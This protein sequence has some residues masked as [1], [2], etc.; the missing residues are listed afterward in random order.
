MSIQMRTLSR[1]SARVIS[2]MAKNQHNGAERVTSTTRRRLFFFIFACRTSVVG[3]YDGSARHP[4]KK[5]LHPPCFVSL[6]TKCDLE[7]AVQ[8]SSA[9]TSLNEHTIQGKASS[10]IRCSYRTLGRIHGNPN[11]ES[12]S[13]YNL[14]RRIATPSISQRTI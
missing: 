7:R 3:S 11:I 13:K 5:L 12:Q 4:P 10:S 6:T 2:N 9:P 8:F 1:A 14:L